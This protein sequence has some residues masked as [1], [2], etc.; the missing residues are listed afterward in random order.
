MQ[1]KRPEIFLLTNFASTEWNFRALAEKVD[2]QEF[3]NSPYGDLN[4]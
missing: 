3:D 1:L 4:Y 2:W